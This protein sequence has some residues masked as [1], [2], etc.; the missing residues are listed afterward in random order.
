[1]CLLIHIQGCIWSHTIWSPTS[2]LI[3]IIRTSGFE[4]HITKLLFCADILNTFEIIYSLLLFYVYWKGPQITP[5][6]FDKAYLYQYL[7]PKFDVGLSTKPRPN[8]THIFPLTI[9]NLFLR[10]LIFSQLCCNSHIDR[11]F[12]FCKKHKTLNTPQANPFT[13]ARDG[14]SYMDVE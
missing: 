8:F 4:T 14:Y 11:L 9:L 7:N 6:V 13:R 12:I 2:L 3:L 1:M 10:C 5:Y